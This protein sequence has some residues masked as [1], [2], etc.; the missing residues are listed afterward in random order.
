MLFEQVQVFYQCF[1]ILIDRVPQV[2]DLIHRTSQ[3]LQLL[4]EYDP[5][6]QRLDR[7]RLGSPCDQLGVPATGRMRL[8]S[9]SDA[10]LERPDVVENGTLKRRSLRCVC[11]RNREGQLA[12]SSPCSWG[13]LTPGGFY[14]HPLVTLTKRVFPSVFYEAPATPAHTHPS[15][16]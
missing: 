15:A 9:P 1:L 2:D 11:R 12:S 4:I 7:L 16:L 10:V 6:R 5:V 14:S 13:H 3:T 8:S